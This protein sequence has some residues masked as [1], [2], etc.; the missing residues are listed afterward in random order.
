MRGYIRQ[1]QQVYVWACALKLDCLG[2]PCEACLN[3][4]R[5]DNIPTASPTLQFT[6]AAALVLSDLSP[7]CFFQ[8]K[9]QV[10][11]AQR[12]KSGHSMRFGLPR[13]SPLFSL[14]PVARKPLPSK[15]PKRDLDK[16]DLNLTLWCVT[17]SSNTGCLVVWFRPICG[18]LNSVQDFVRRR[19]DRAGRIT[20]TEL[21]D[22]ST[23]S[24]KRKFELVACWN[25]Q[26][27]S[28]PIRDTCGFEPYLASKCQATRHPSGAVWN[29]W[30]FRPL[31]EG[32]VWVVSFL[33]LEPGTVESE[34]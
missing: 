5:P 20:L 10:F 16:L 29:V 8:S 9:Y 23:W 26:K 27:H 12:C 11:R 22:G 7:L 17:V 18:L 15:A 2:V 24:P 34:S 32:G 31:Q 33:L 14:W 1:D 4:V 19:H 13:E 6:K 25:L 21:F 30:R 28:L 3:L